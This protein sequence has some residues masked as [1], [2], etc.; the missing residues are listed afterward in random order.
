MIPLWRPVWQSAWKPYSTKHK[1]HQRARKYSTPTPRTP[2]FSRLSISSSTWTATPTCWCGPVTNSDSSYSTGKPTSGQYQPVQPPFLFKAF[3]SLKKVG[4][5]L[6]ISVEHSKFVGMNM[7]TPRTHTQPT[8]PHPALFCLTLPL[9]F[10]DTLLWRVWCVY[11]R[12][13][14]QNLSPF[15]TIITLLLLMSLF[16][17]YRYLALESMCLLATSEFSHEAVKKHQETVVTS[18]KVK[19]MI[20]MV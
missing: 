19:T 16:V 12:E 5:Q 4:R 2:C 8:H 9:Y 18:L 11:S 14:S 1:N 10:T 7:I 13:S 20:L 6:G 15:F 3:L 17:F